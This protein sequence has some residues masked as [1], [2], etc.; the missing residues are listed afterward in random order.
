MTNASSI[1]DIPRVLA[2]F[3]DAIRLQS[4]AVMTKVH[5]IEL[6]Q[7]S[8]DPDDISEF[9]FLVDHQHIKYIT[10]D[11]YIFDDMD[12]IFEPTLIEILLPLLPAGD[13]NLAGIFQATSPEKSSSGNAEPQIETLT[14]VLPGIREIW[15]PLQIDY[16]ELEV[17]NHLRSNVYEAK[18]A[19]LPGQFIVKFARFDYEIER[20][21][22]ETAA[23]KWIDGHN[24]GP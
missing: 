2:A 10:V 22:R 5:D 24:I 23:H 9:C 12:L 4:T 14:R 11:P 17:S 19:K 16:L 3:T 7:A 20:L 21:E 6:L 1:V 15:H 8:T 13:W 18:C